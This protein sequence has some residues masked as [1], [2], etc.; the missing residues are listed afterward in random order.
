MNT[1][2]KQIYRFVSSICEALPHVSP[3]IMQRWIEHPAALARYM[4]GLRFFSE[5]PSNYIWR[6][7]QIGTHAPVNLPR[8]LSL[9]G[10]G[11][12]PL[13]E[14]YFEGGSVVQVVHSDTSLQIPLS[15]RSVS[16]LGFVKP[17][18]YDEILNCAELKGYGKCPILVGPY[19]RMEYTDQPDGE[20]LVL[21]M[22][23]L[24]DQSNRESIFG[25]THQNGQK[26][27][28]SYPGEA[29]NTWPLNTNFVFAVDVH[30]TQKC[31]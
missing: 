23:A 11:V 31:V 20:I 16:E 21:A 10:Y 3:E 5:L 12:G 1:S 4:G 6:I 25:V 2:S 14:K 18:R 19:L 27:L 15:I 30:Q 24:P 9:S 8:L 22:D 28:R 17:P 13:I 29:N 26:R 7:L